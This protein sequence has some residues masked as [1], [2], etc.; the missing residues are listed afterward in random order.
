MSK[1]NC[2]MIKTQKTRFAALLLVLVTLFI[3]LFI[4]INAAETNTSDDV[5][6]EETA[7]RV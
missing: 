1:V 4:P 3:A 6:V 7:P 5:G 2:K